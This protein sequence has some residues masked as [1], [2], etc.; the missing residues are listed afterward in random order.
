M[1]SCVTMNKD[2][3]WS[4]AAPLDC[5]ELALLSVRAK[6][7][8]TTWFIRRDLNRFDFTNSPNVG[9]FYIK[10]TFCA[11]WQI[12]SSIR[13]HARARSQSNEAR[14]MINS[15]C[16]VELAICKIHS[17]RE[18]IQ[19]KS[20]SSD[21]PSFQFQHSFDSSFISTKLIGFHNLLKYIHAQP[22]NF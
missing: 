2:H 20:R 3:P 21:L 1:K 16:H 11:L 6:P 17:R 14:S 22:V 19:G 15:V 5:H 18:I 7:L 9:Q 13:V 12:A 10:S 8:Y 4:W